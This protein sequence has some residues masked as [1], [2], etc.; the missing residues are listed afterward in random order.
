[1][2]DSLEAEATLVFSGLI[3]GLNAALID[4]KPFTLGQLSAATP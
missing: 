2:T 1:M 3:S 4:A